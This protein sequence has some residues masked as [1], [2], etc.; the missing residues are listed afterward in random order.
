MIDYDFIGDEKE[1]L[2]YLGAGNNSGEDIKKE[3]YKIREELKDI[4][5]FRF[6]YDIF[7]IEIKEDGVLL[8]DCGTIL[9]GEDIKS[10]LKESNKCVIMGATLGVEVDK[11]INYYQKV[12]MF[13]ALIMNAVATAFIEEGCGFIEK[14]IKKEYCSQSGDIT[15]RYSPGYGDLGLDIQKDLLNLIDA[16]KNIGISSSEGN[17]LTPKKSVTAIIGIIQKGT[18]I[19]KRDCQSCSSYGNCPYRRI[20]ESCEG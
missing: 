16:F 15:W 3:L 6:I 2:R 18:K 12:D 20:G 19:K 7:D 4:V 11:K 5:R 1:I 17:M 10:H 8:K 9:K 14:L 13:K